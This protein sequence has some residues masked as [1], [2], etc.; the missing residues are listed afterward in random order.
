MSYSVTAAAPEFK[1]GGT[2]DVNMVDAPE[3]GSEIAPPPAEASA[4]AKGAPKPMEDAG[5][6]RS[7]M[8]PPARAAARPA[9]EEKADTS[10]VGSLHAFI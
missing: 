8:P 7:M 2:E 4:K 9:A 3:A 10:T 6:S 1:S 5:M